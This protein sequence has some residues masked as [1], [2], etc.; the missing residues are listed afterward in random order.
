MDNTWCHFGNE[1]RGLCSGWDVSCWVG[2]LKERLF[3]FLVEVR[4]EPL[5]NRNEWGKGKKVF[6]TQAGRSGRVQLKV[7][8]AFALSWS[9]V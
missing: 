5:V 8:G 4:K 7:A 9:L 2:C 6:L 3:P 1:K